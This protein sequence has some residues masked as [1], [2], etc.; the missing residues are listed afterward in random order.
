M[1]LCTA[2]I[3]HNPQDVQNGRPARPQRAQ[4]RIVPLRYVEPLCDARTKLAAFF[5]ILLEFILYPAER[6]DPQ[7]RVGIPIELIVHHHCSGIGLVGQIPP[8]GEERPMLIDVPP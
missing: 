3:Q 4:K 2:T 1:S 8:F 7:P 5:N 6:A